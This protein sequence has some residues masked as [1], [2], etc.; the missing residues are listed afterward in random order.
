MGSEMCIRD[1][2]NGD[3]WHIPS[4]T[5]YNAKFDYSFDVRDVDTRVQLGI[6]NF[7]D[8]RAPLADEPYGF[9]KDAHRDWGRYYYLDLRLRFG[10]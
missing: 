5:T 7:T 2:G 10:R 9:F 1:R 3:P 4:M 6:N 8:A